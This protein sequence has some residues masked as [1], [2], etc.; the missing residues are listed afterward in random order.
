M[1]GVRKF[2]TT[3][4]ALGATAL[5]GTLAFADAAADRA[6]AEAKKFAGA[7]LT[8]VWEAGLQAI[9]PQTFSGPKWEQLTGVKIK[10][11][12]V[13]TAEMFTK[14]MQEY[15]AGTGAYDT[16]NVIPAWMPDLVNA[17]ALEPLD[18][19]VDKYGFRD[20]LQK[21]AP[22]FRDNWMTVN[23][24]I[25]GLTK[26][27]YS[28]TSEFGKKTKSTPFG[29]TDM[30]FNPL[31]LVIGANTSF[32]ARS[33][34]VFQQH[35]KDTLRKTAAHMGSA[36]VE[37]LQN[38]NIFNDGAWF[39]LT[40]KDARVD[41]VVQLEHGKPLIY[42]KNRDKGIR[43]NGMELEVVHLGNGNGLTEKDLLIHD[44]TN[45]NP[46]YAFLL[47]QMEDMP[48]FPTPI[49]VLRSWN[50]DRYEDVMSRQVQDVIAKRGP[51][52]LAKLL[53][54]GDTWEVS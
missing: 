34:D 54:S 22:T 38:C 50:R 41:N 29:T 45:P 53:H 33:V 8:V 27:Q 49:G 12:E 7:T 19:L 9:D 20:D 25:Y 36:Y 32:V 2:V 14:I 13:Q 3:M 6:V 40:E 39:D 47:A 1:S 30:P 51:G 35:L 26:G 42:G 31:G 48:G 4:L 46:A 15:R 44:E 10:V 52:D 23:N 24:K 43:L 18:A 28:P 37:I 17:G 21:I 16:L 11:V 5:S